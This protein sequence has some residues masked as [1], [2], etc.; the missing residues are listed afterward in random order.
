MKENQTLRQEIQEHETRTR[1]DMYEIRTK[2]QKMENEQFRL[3]QENTAQ[4]ERLQSILAT[5]EIEKIDNM[6]MKDNFEKENE[7]LQQKIRIYELEAKCKKLEDDR[8]RSKP[9]RMENEQSKL[10]KQNTN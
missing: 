9:Q 3:Q 10:Q 6:R 1:Q 8:T 4:K 7:K 2:S 5:L